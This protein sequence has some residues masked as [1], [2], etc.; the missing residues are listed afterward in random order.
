MRLLIITPQAPEQNSTFIKA[1]IKYL[2]P[3]KILHT[4]VRPYI[5]DNK[6]ILGFP[7]NLRLIQILIKRFLPW[8]YTY[9]Y[10]LSL[11][12]FIIAN[13]IDYALIN[14]GPH[15]ANVANAFKKTGVPFIVHFHGADA[16]VYKVIK[17]YKSNKNILK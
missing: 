3:F 11:S 2:M 13:R 17:K 14:Y 1:Q 5:C 8:A 10:T 12:K 15:G 4:N 16:F 9:F 7:L 6:S